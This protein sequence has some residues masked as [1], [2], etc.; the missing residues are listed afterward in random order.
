[1]CPVKY[2]AEIDEKLSTQ[3]ATPNLTRYAICSKSKPEYD[4]PSLHVSKIFLQNYLI[5]NSI[6]KFSHTIMT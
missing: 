2:D 6:D 3:P 5:V 1:V 4:K